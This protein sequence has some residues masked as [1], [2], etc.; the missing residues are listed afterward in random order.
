[1]LWHWSSLTN[2][3]KNNGFAGFLGGI[4]AAALDR[5]ARHDINIGCVYDVLW[6][7]QGVDAALRNGAM[8][9]DCT[10]RIRTNINL[11]P[12][13]KLSGFDCTASEGIEDLFT[14]LDEVA[15]ASKR[16]VDVIDRWETKAG[17]E[18]DFHV[19]LCHNSKDK[20]SVRQLYE[21]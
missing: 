5:S 18:E 4:L 1:S 21:K 11:D 6:D 7:K 3:P 20:P 13:R 15:M 8:C 10:E 17:V 2:L 9:R 19:F 16:Q 14:I 12:N